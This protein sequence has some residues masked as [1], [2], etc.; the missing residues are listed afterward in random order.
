[1][2]KLKTVSKVIEVKDHKKKEIEFELK[3]IKDI[4][5]V[6]QAKLDSIEKSFS[7]TMVKFSEKH[8]G[9]VIKAGDVELAYNYLLTLSENI[10]TQ[11]KIINKKVEE[12][13]DKHNALVEAHKE[14][15]VFEA[16]KKKI[17]HKEDKEKNRAEQREADFVFMRRR[18]R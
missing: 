10:N 5:D 4:I 6:E 16:L 17:I 2:T 14:K 11:K 12:F 8:G 1:M 15:K 9:T 18:G 3:K 13:G 7:D